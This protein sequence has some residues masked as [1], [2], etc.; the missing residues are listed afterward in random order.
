MRY[1][2]FVGILIYHIFLRPPLR[3]LDK[4]KLSSSDSCG[5]HHMTY[6]RPLL[7]LHYNIILVI[8]K[9]I[10]IFVLVKIR[11]VTHLKLSAEK[12]PST[13]LQQILYSDQLTK[14]AILRMVKIFS[15]FLNLHIYYFQ[16]TKLNH[17]YYAHC[18]L[19]LQ[20]H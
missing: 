5:N 19:I 3:W 16:F 7:L 18:V 17:Y 20:I 15:Y 4:S 14:Y 2:N 9:P 1:G 12:Y 13:C 8:K 10:W 6:P 11:N